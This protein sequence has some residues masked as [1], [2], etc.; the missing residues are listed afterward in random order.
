MFLV[1]I[2]GYRRDSSVEFSHK[3]TS[4]MNAIFGKYSM[5]VPKMNFNLFDSKLVRLSENRKE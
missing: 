2:R 4:K 1:I 5:H 3:L